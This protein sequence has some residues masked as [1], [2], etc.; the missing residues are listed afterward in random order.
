MALKKFYIKVRGS[1]SKKYEWS[2]ESNKLY[3]NNYEI[4]KT[5]SLQEAIEIAKSHCNADRDSL[6]EMSD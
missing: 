3:C 1:W 5:T 2:T 6:V 4:G